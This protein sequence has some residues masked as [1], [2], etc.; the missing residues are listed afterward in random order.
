M[1]IQRFIV[2]CS[3]EDQKVLAIVIVDTGPYTR[4]QYRF[5][6]RTA[7]A[8][9]KVQLQLVEERLELIVR[10]SIPIASV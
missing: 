8:K 10:I 2:E 9:L 6:K 3:I 1:I 7:A 4:Q 5:R